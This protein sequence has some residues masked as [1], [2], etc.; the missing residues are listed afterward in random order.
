MALQSLDLSKIGWVGVWSGVSFIPRQWGR[1]QPHCSPLCSPS[2]AATSRLGS[3][4]WW[5]G[6]SY[7]SERPPTMPANTPASPATGCGSHLLPQPSSQCC[8]RVLQS[9]TS[10]GHAVTSSTHGKALL[11][12]PRGIPT[13]HGGKGVPLQLPW[14]SQHPAALTQALA[15]FLLADPAEVTTMLPET[16]LPKGMQGVIRCPTRANPPLLSV[17]WMR[18]GRPLQLDKVPPLAS[19]PAF[20][21]LEPLVLTPCSPVPAPWLV[22]ETRWLHHHCDGKRRCAGSIHV[23]PVQQ[24]RHR[25]RVPAHTCPVEGEAGQV[26]TLPEPLV[27]GAPTLLCRAAQV[28]C[29]PTGL[30]CCRSVPLPACC[31]APHHACLSSR[32]PLPSQCAPRRS[33]SRR[34]AGSW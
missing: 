9:L 17:S 2:L 22:R 5:T 25:W 21:P 8:V 6:V 28:P 34:W 13:G 16:H 29:V 24:L 19:A 3:A 20:P 33:T 23:Y 18:D 12:Q 7:S 1:S 11:G 32:I 26:G 10:L 14:G 4:S 15:P 31:G 27:R 30:P